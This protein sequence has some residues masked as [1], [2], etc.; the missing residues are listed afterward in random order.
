MHDVDERISTLRLMVSH[1]VVLT[2]N[3]IMKSWKQASLMSFFKFLR[4]H[5]EIL[6]ERFQYHNIHLDLL[7]TEQG[8]SLDILFSLAFQHIL[9]ALNFHKNYK[10]VQH[11]QL[12]E[13]YTMSFMGAFAQSIPHHVNVVDYQTSF[14][15]QTDGGQGACFTSRC[16]WVKA[17]HTENWLS[18]Q[19]SLTS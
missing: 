5:T 8:G 11:T 19:K 6:L 18:E 4:C 7:R 12:N 17:W 2:S 3:I 1:K 13:D 14:K 16:D 9:T 15:E 10:T